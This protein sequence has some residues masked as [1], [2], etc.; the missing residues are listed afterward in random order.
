MSKTVMSIVRGFRL[1]A[2]WLLVLFI[3]IGI[4]LFF[5][6]LLPRLSLGFAAT[7][8]VQP[9]TW[10]A[11]SFFILRCLPRQKNL[12]KMSLRR[13]LIKIAA[14]IALFQIY[15]YLVAGFFEVFGKSPN[16]FTVKGIAINL[17]FVASGL[18]GME[19]SRAWLINRMVKKEAA[20]IPLL[21]TLLYT[22]F[23]LSLNQV[24]RWG[25]SIEEVTK[26]LGNT[27]LPL[28][29]E[30]LMASF[31]AMWGGVVPALLYR[32]ILQ[33]YNWFCP[34]LPDLNWAMKA[35]VGTVPPVIGL[36]IVQQVCHA[37]LYPGKFKRDSSKGML[38]WV[39]VCVAAVVVMWFSV[40]VFPI[41]PT[42]I[43]SG[44]MR[45]LIQIGDMVIVGRVNETVLKKGDIIQ[46][47]QK[48]GAMPTVHRIDAIEKQND[49]TLYITK[50]DN[51][52]IRDSEPVLPEQVV[53]KVICVVPKAGWPTI[54]IKQL[55]AKIA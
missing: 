6:V 26:F 39:V 40:G 34:F 10:L 12:A 5:N 1:P 42:V 50:G 54:V 25:T 49:K 24:T 13:Q 32:G 15:L 16:S 46:F 33:G 14:G 2:Q 18:I 22:V 9:L 11:L 28:F 38:N 37:K 7:Y 52:R 17:I 44:S 23:D 21:I 55:L 8:L 53:G 43:I 48:E 36:V 51:N 20:F 31:L 41:R 3:M 35:L 45:P 29:S 19:L 47:R 27:L 4:Y 30:N